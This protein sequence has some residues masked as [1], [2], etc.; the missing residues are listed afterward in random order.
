MDYMEHVKICENKL[1]RLEIKHNRACAKLSDYLM[2]ASE[3]ENRQEILDYFKNQVSLMREDGKYSVN[4]VIDLIKSGFCKPYDIVKNYDISMPLI[5]K[6]IDN[7]DCELNDKLSQEIQNEL[8]NIDK[9]N[10]I[11]IDCDDMSNMFSSYEL[12]NE[13]KRKMGFLP[14]GFDSTDAVKLNESNNILEAIIE[15]E[16]S[17]IVVMCPGCYSISIYE[18]GLSRWKCLDCSTVFLFD[19]SRI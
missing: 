8:F 1:N 14:S 4:R 12:T 6:R 7:V 10:N 9:I 3:I 5:N 11:D 16:D 2:S 17:E 15:F 19:R 18:D 13:G